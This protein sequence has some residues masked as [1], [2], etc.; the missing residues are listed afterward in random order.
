MEELFQRLDQRIRTLLQKFEHV[1]KSKLSLIHDKEQL[2][3]K[4][5]DITA[6]IETM[7]TQ[8]KSMEGL[9]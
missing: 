4:Q 8:L 5:K 9:L 2:L 3:A 6:Q 1:Q 7:I